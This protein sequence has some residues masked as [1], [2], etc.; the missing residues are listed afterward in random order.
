M[1]IWLDDQ[2]NDVSCPARH[3][4]KGFIGVDSALKAIRLIK[5]GKVEFISFDHDLGD[6]KCSGYIVARYISGWVCKHSKGYGFSR[7]VL[8]MDEMIRAFVVCVFML[9]CA[10]I[11]LKSCAFVTGADSEAAFNSAHKWAQENKI[12]TTSVNCL[13]GGR[14]TVNSEGKFIP[15][16]CPTMFEQGSC[17]VVLKSVDIQ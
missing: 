7:K 12:K 9:I 2:I 11:G 5:S 17:V 10:A 4:P 6:N 15:L 13:N 16:Q 8:A 3:T 14:C 1:K